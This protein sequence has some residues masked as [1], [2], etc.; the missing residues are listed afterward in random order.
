MSG[1]ITIRRIGHFHCPRPKWV[2]LRYSSQVCRPR[3]RRRSCPLPR[4]FG[5]FVEQAITKANSFQFTRSARLTLAHRIRR[6][7]KDKTCEKA[8]LLN[9]FI[10]RNRGWVR[11]PVKSSILGVPRL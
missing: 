6:I 3:P 8:F 1:F 11:E 9:P 10:H 2:H 4:S 5:Y 7:S